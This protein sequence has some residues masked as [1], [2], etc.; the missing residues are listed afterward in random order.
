MVESVKIAL[1][2]VRRREGGGEGERRGERKE[3]ERGDFKRSYSL[4]FFD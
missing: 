3:E 1:D 4:I 2:K